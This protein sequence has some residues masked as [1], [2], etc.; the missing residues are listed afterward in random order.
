MKRFFL[1]AAI[2][3]VLIGIAVLVTRVAIFDWA[4]A[5][6]TI[7]AYWMRTAIDRS[8]AAA[9]FAFLSWL[10]LGQKHK[11]FST[12]LVVII[13]VIFSGVISNFYL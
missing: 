1:D 5:P 11:K 13:A 4:D 9:C 7:R 6:A 3:A 12:I 8:G 10:Y 2:V